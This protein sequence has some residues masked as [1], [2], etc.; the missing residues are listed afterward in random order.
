[1][2]AAIEELTPEIGVTAACDALGFPRATWHRRHRPP[3]VLKPTSPRPPNSWGLTSEERQGFLDLANSAEFVDKAPPQIYHTLLDHGCYICSVRTMYRILAAEGQVKER[4]NQLR[5]P[6][7]K[8]P[9]LLATGPNQLWSWDITKLRGPVKGAYYQLYVVIDVFSRYVVGW[10]LASHESDELAKQLLETSYEKH[11]VEPGQ[12]TVHA[13]RGTSM[14]SVGVAGLLERL[15]VRKSH[16]RPGNS[17]DNPY[18]ESQFKTMK[19]RPDYPDRFGSRED[20]LAFCRPFFDWYNNENYHSGICWL[21]PASVH[22]GQADRILATR[23][24]TL[25]SFYQ[26][27]PKRF[28]NGAPK[29][30]KLPGAVWI[31]RPFGLA[32]DE[33]LKVE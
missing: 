6:E 10:L 25:T 22:Y 33:D 12:L 3:A 17:D 1:M 14:T 30:Y 2:L 28:R 23:H 16:S 31:N 19:Y 13:D 7:Y 11:G 20:A 5:H 29:R 24:V 26:V 18:S 21:T 15:D 8:R 9:E 4:R 27:N 32:A